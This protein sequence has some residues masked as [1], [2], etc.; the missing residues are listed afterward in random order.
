[1]SAP[2]DYAERYR[3]AGW[4]GVIAFDARTKWPPPAGFTGYDGRW[5]TND[6]IARWRAEG[7]ENLGNRVPHGVIGLDVDC[8]N[9]KPG[10]KTL[11]RLCRQLGA[12][13]KTWTSTSRN[14][15]S[16]IRWYRVP[17][18]IRDDW[19]TTAGPG[20][21]IIR[22]AHRYGMMPPSIHPDTGNAY[23]WVRPD[24]TDAGDSDIPSPGDL[25]EL[26]ATWVEYLTGVSANGEKKPSHAKPGSRAK[27]REKRKD[28]QHWIIG[29]P[30]GAPCEF[31][32]KLAADALASARREHGDA[33]DHT[34]DAVLALLRGG[35]AGHRGIPGVLVRVRDT[36]VATVSDKRDTNTASGEFERFTLD[37]AALVLSTPSERAANM[38]D[39]P[40][41]DDDDR[42]AI[43][44][45]EQLNAVTAEAIDAILERPE[46]GVYVR[47]RQLVT[48]ARD[49]SPRERWLRRPPGSPVITP[50]GEARMM[51]LLDSAARWEKFAARDKKWV[52][53][54]PPTWV[55]TQVL[56]RT[57]WP[58]GYLDAVTETPTLRP[59]GSILD[60]QGWDEATGLLYD[61]PPGAAWPAVPANPSRDDARQAAK[62]L[63]DPVC[64]FPFV[65]DSDKAAYVAA[66]LTILARHVIDGPVPMFPIRAPSPGTGKGLLAVVIGLIGTGRP[67]AAMTYPYGDDELRKRITALAVSG[68]ALVL[69]DNLSGS[70]GSDSLAAALTATD[71]EDRVLG[72]TE[73]VRVPLRAVWLGTGNNLG[74]RRTLGRR[75]VP[76]DLDAKIEVPEDRTDF[77]YTDLIGHV[78]KNRP[79]L[80]TAALTLL[81]AFWLAGRPRHGQ[82]R[83]GSFESWDDV[84]RS[85]VVWC[86]LEDPASTE[87]GVGRGR[88]R[89]QADD[90]TEV[91]GT[92]LAELERVFSD[93]RF[94]ATLVMKSAKDDEV[95]ATAVEAAAAPKRTGRVT[96]ASLG[97][98]LRSLRDRPIQRRVLRRVKESWLVQGVEA[99]PQPEPDMADIADIATVTR[100]FF[101]VEDCEI[102]EMG[103]DHVVDVGHVGT[104]REGSGAQRCAG[105]CG[106][107]VGSPGRLCPICQFGTPEPERI[108]L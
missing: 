61:P 44:V 5:P 19:P 100:E 95:L 39:C 8:Y 56:A 14:D 40:S 105:G 41:D 74:F 24:G 71:W 70:L 94:T 34:R 96:A 35:E 16:G 69:L 28:A 12:P 103:R 107:E 68:T 54:R 62:A 52:A 18:E 67:P 25:A 101:A 59:D 13:E 93:D 87:E 30:G 108:K 98:T 26:P 36:Y 6:D 79:R 7:K 77:K 50:V 85:A 78:R 64:N 48:V 89:A 53:T 75:V 46:L 37:G 60:T 11:R 83:M 63:L 97:A 21:E 43:R 99:E 47:G 38:C 86:E 66:T 49:G 82:T 72:Q 55:A 65:A 57:E 51:A 42:P 90:D 20:I 3:A 29:L 1:M 15:G 31:T 73:M 27:Q 17:H 58:F 81:R 32:G 106:R 92:L 22:Y 4:L 104:A 9:G 102:I 88:I 33:Y 80:V 84:V 45:R 76:I 23:R 10:G 2:L 91:Y